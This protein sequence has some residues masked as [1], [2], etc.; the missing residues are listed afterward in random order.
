MR[1]I[2][3]GAR[4][5]VIARNVQKSQLPVPPLEISATFELEHPR[6][7]SFDR[8]ED[9]RVQG[10]LGT[11]SFCG[12]ILRRR[13]L[14]ERVQLDTLAAEAGILENDPPATPVPGADQWRQVP[15]FGAS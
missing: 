7:K 4:C 5:S 9:E 13:Q 3:M 11:G 12:R 6:N 1:S 10:A 8:M 15:P 2:G 14:K